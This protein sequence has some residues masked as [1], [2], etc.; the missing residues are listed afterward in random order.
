MGARR[1]GFITRR[2]SLTSV[3]PIGFCPG[4]AID[5]ASFSRLDKPS[6]KVNSLHRFRRGFSGSSDAESSLDLMQV[7]CLPPACRLFH[8]ILLSTLRGCTI[9]VLKDDNRTR[10]GFARGG[11]ETNFL[12]VVVSI[13]SAGQHFETVRRD[14]ASPGLADLFF[15]GAGPPCC[16]LARSFT[17]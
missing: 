11:F 12:W 15:R 8:S 4:Q 1:L 10:P 14:E 16:I 7:E 13:V 6:L 17:K 9:I 3:R 2:L 5:T